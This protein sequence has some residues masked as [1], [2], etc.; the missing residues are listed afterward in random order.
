MDA[1]ELGKMTT[2]ERIAY[3]GQIGA[4]WKAYTTRET[5]IQIGEERGE[6]RGEIR[7]E[8]RGES[9]GL[10]KSKLVAKS[11][12]ACE[13]PEAIASKWQLPVQE[14]LELKEAMGL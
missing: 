7:G 11:L 1:A 10:N 5:A 2:E 4:E 12:R 9:K 3:M 13:S 6:K 14:V 8:I